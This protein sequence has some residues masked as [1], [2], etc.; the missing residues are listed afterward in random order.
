MIESALLDRT[1][2]FTVRVAL[3]AVITAEF[4]RLG[5][6][7]ITVETGDFAEVRLNVALEAFQFCVPAI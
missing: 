6:A 1:P 5:V 4:M 2:V 7:I 3:G